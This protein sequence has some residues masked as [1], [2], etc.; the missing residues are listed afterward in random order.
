[1]PASL[2]SNCL[3]IYLKRTNDT[4]RARALDLSYSARARW[5][6]DDE[7]SGQRRELGA[8][9]GCPKMVTGAATNAPS[10]TASRQFA[11]NVS[12]ARKSSRRLGR[13]IR[14]TSLKKR[15]GKRGPPTTVRARTRIPAATAAPVV[16]CAEVDQLDCDSSGV[17][18]AHRVDR[19]NY[20]TTLARFSVQ[21]I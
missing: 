13:K 3:V 7:S 2:I 8:S 17:H 4:V 14:V 5:E 10:P 6:H 18:G 12:L 1:M 9:K 20:Q 21:A 19:H 11:A 16:L 15:S